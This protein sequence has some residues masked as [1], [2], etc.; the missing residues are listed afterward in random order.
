[1]LPLSARLELTSKNQIRNAFNSVDTDPLDWPECNRGVVTIYSFRPLYKYN[2]KGERITM[3][4]SRTQ[5]SLEPGI[6]VFGDD[7]RWID[8]DIP[9][10]AM[11]RLSV[12][13]KTISGHLNLYTS[14]IHKIRTTFD[15][16]KRQF[17]ESAE[18][19]FCVNEADTFK[20]APQKTR[21]QQF[22]EYC[23]LS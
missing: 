10:E 12:A 23:G 7:E 5:I 16:L 11:K 21:I 3:N 2:E 13:A 8:L 19:Y 9:Y 1:M 4:H 15:D 20:Q 18:S 6:S 14:G 22:L 17:S